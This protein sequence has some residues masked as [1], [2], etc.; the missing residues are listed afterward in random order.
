MDDDAYLVV[1]RDPT[2]ASTG[3]Y[4]CSLCN[5]EFH[6]DPEKPDEM[7]SNFA[8]H[9]GYAHRGRRKVGEDVSQTAARVVEEAMRRLKK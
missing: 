4:R 8:V 9:V 3:Y 7:A 6:S 2:G 5:A 1:L